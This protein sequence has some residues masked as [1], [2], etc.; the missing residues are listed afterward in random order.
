MKTGKTIQM[1]RTTVGLNGSMKLKIGITVAAVAGCLLALPLT[2]AHNHTDCEPP[3]DGYCR[4]LA[5]KTPDV[6]QIDNDHRCFIRQ[7][8]AG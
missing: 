4:K 2:R 3:A 6:V 7:H 5:T 1:T 8:R